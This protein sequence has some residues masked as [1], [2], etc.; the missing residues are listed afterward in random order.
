MG[1]KIKAVEI[2]TLVTYFMNLHMMGF[3]TIE[4]TTAD[5][6]DTIR[7]T[8]YPPMDSDTGRNIGPLSGETDMGATG[9]EEYDFD[10]VINNLVVDA[11]M[12][13]EN[14]YNWILK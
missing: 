3:T 10:T 1:D 13:L 6:K 2:T 14:S 12:E 9:L 8:V 4:V 11:E 5:P 7:V